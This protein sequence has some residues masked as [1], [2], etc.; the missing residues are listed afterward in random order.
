MM[1]AIRPF[2]LSLS[3]L[4]FSTDVLF[5]QNLCGELFSEKFQ[6]RDIN[7]Y[8]Y[9]T[10]AKNVLV[11]SPAS[12]Q[13]AQALIRSSA[14]TRTHV[15]FAGASHST[16]SILVDNGIYIS[17]E[18]MNRILGLEIDP[19]HGPVVR[20]E[21]GVKPGDLANYLAEQGYSLGF[22]YPYYAALTMAGLVSTGAHGS[23]RMHT[24]VS[25]QNIVELVMVNG[26]G[27]IETIDRNT[28]KKLKAAKVSLGLLGFIA[29]MK[30]KVVPDFNIEF[31][32]QTYAGDTALLKKEGEVQWGP[33]ADTEYF[34]W[35]PA[36]DRAVKVEG[37]ITDKP[38]MPGAKSVV[39]GSG[40]YNIAKEKLTYGA[41]SAGLN[42]PAINKQ[43]EDRRFAG[44]SEGPPPY[45]LLKDGQEVRSQNVVG[46]SS[47][48]LISK[49]IPLNPVY[50]TQDISFAFRIEDAP[51]VMRLIRDF[52]AKNEFYHP[53]LSMFLRFAHSDGQSFLSHIEKSKNEKPGLYVLAEFF[54][55][56]EYNQ[57]NTPTVSS[58]LRDQMI[59]LLVSKDLITLH[60]GKNTDGV[61]QTQA[62]QQQSRDNLI[63]FERVRRDMDPFGIF[64]N[65]FSRDF[66]RLGQKSNR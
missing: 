33:I 66:V 12:I 14:R 8:N 6:N 53:F 59:R 22:A 19:V 49:P 61:F 44:L 40:D 35:F 42:N 29:E 24:A 52:C 39:L 21:A 65:Q 60:W 55:P 47:T 18:K 27:Q 23:S 36:M 16:S 4:T 34:Y 1:S 7:S 10:V 56:K 45:V 11:Y 58:R 2:I 54:E 38:A 32:S 37:R 25:S 5:A 57:N 46:R 28:P 17:N 31:T 51:K 30:V 3:F 64:Q 41:L 43:I 15:R 9:E 13:E 26:K 63:Q 62:N 50:T 48:M 20:V